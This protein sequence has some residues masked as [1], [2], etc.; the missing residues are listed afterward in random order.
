MRMPW[1]SG[2]TFGNSDE[3]GGGGRGFGVVVVNFNCVFMAIITSESEFLV[4]RTF[5]PV[6]EFFEH[7]VDLA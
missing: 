5:I 2:G 6:W 1:L 4:N 3:E 7:F